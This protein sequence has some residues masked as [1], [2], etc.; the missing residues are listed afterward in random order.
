MLQI[1]LRAFDEC[2]WDDA[3]QRINGQRGQAYAKIGRRGVSSRRQ[4]E[5]FSSY[6]GR[7]SAR[8]LQERQLQDSDSEHIGVSSC[9]TELERL[10]RRFDDDDDFKV[11]QRLSFKCP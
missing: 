6:G 9:E 7:D 8:Q 5:V 3:E 2:S 10:G 1:L 11:K 4:P